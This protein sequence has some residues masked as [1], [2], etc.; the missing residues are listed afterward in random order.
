MNSTISNE[1]FELKNN[2]YTHFIDLLLDI[3]NKTSVNSRQLDLLINIDYF[4]DFGNCNELHRINE[5]FDFFK[6]GK[7]KSIK[8]DKISSEKLQNIIMKYSTDK[9]KNGSESKS[10][11]ITDIMGLLYE[12][13]DY[14]R[15]LNLPDLDYKV[16]CANQQEILGYID[17]TTNKEEDRRKLLLTKVVPLISKD[18]GNAWGYAL[19]TKSV[20]SGKTSRLT[21][22]SEL[23]DKKPVKA[24]DMVYAKRVDKNKSGYWYL[25]DYD[26]VV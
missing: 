17:L 2:E 25:W 21:L 20:G 19:F 14:I 11:T 12:C 15:S 7:A 23:Y 9:N 1:L 5:V 6:Q 26:Y 22:K 13:E 24:M 18:S 8:K 4:I 16:K 10:Y 3:E